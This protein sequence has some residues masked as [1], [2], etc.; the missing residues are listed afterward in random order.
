MTWSHVLILSL[1]T[2]RRGQLKG[3]YRNRQI[4]LF[5]SEFSGNGSCGFFQQ[6]SP[7]PFYLLFCFI[8]SWTNGPWQ[9]SVT[10]SIVWP[11]PNQRPQKLLRTITPAIARDNQSTL[12]R[13]NFLWIRFI[14]I[15]HSHINC[16]TVTAAGFIDINHFY[17]G[18]ITGSF[19]LW[20]K[21]SISILPIV[22]ESA[23]LSVA[24]AQ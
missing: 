17:N 16:T 7:K 18:M 24:I 20:P 22:L 3:I 15:D 13:Y 5:S 21:L 2:G 19:K 4:S 9:E 23:A 12:L 6:R 8:E 1:E 11:H 14:E 10:E